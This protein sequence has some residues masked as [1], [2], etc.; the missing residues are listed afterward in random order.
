MCSVLRDF[1]QIYIGHSDDVFIISLATALY[2]LFKGWSAL[3]IAVSNQNVEVAKL[4]LLNEAN[5]DATTIDVSIS[6]C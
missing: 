5:V 3:Y 4:L 6:V 1:I 2:L